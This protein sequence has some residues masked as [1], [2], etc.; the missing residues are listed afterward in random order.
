MSLKKHVV[1]RFVGGEMELKCLLEIINYISALYPLYDLLKS[2]LG[3][4]VDRKERQPNKYMVVE[5]YCC[6]N[7]TSLDSEQWT[8]T[9]LK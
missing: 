1:V 2:R 4:V 6:E 7:N 8:K 3:T 9:V 5:L